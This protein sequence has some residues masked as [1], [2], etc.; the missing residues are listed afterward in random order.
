MI[1]ALILLK[2]CS[3]FLGFTIFRLDCLEGLLDGR[4]ASAEFREAA[5]FSEKKGPP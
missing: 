3:N 5:G 2:P 1:L 4:F